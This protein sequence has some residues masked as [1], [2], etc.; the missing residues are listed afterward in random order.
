MTFWTFETILSATSGERKQGR[1]SKRI[2]GFSTDSRTI[3]PGEC[4]VALSGPRHDGHDHVARAAQ[5]GASGALVRSSWMPPSNLSG[6]FLLVG[7]QDPL[8]ALGELARAHRASFHLPVIGVTGSC[9]KTTTKEMIARVLSGHVSLLK[10]PGTENNAIGVPRTLLKLRPGHDAVVCE[11]GM[12]HPGEI[13]RLSRILQPTMAVLTNIGPA[14]LA[15]LGTVEEVYRAKL[16]I[17]EYLPEGAPLFVNAD[18]EHLARLR[19]RRFRMVR[20]GMGPHSDLR[21]RDLETTSRGV[22]FRLEGKTRLVLRTP[23][24][25]QVYNALAAYAVGRELGV[26]LRRIVHALET[27]RPLAGRM[28]I[29]R[30]AGITWI[31]DSYNANPL[32]TRRAL[33]YLSD[34]FS[35][36]RKA[37]VLGDMLELG[38]EAPAWHRE[39][40]DRVV[41][42]SPD[43]FIGVGSQ[44]RLALRHVKARSNIPCRAFG[45]AAGAAEFLRRWLQPKDVVLVKGS[46]RLRMEQVIACSTNSSI[47]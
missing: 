34:A 24:T 3:K 21:A 20:Y 22:G 36:L 16:E 25:H 27:Y 35:D 5:R 44:M 33:E 2:T 39:I 40:G 8:E 4:F 7:V 17:L 47:L 26:P 37:V 46:H 15:G 23:G 13:R 10:N 45:N 1:V 42:I 14:H 32:S 28:Q 19:S 30:K 12:N 31:N 43:V 9:G 29:V 38:R 18:D 41:Q 6:D 11:L